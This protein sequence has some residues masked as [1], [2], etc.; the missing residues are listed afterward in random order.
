MM[1]MKI[2]MKILK[3]NPCYLHYLWSDKQSCWGFFWKLF[4]GMKI[5]SQKSILSCSAV[6]A[7]AEDP[8]HEELCQSLTSSSILK[9]HCLSK[10]TC[11]IAVT[12]LSSGTLKVTINSNAIVP[13]LIDCLAA[14]IMSRNYSNQKSMTS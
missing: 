3:V 5:Y 7:S 12:V 13:S 4:L 9:T 8:C 10:Y 11:K 2:S 14:E 1:M 6:S